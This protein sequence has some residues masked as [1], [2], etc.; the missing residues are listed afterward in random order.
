MRVSLILAMLLLVGCQQAPILPAVPETLKRGPIQD[1]RSGRSLTPRELAIALARSPRVM[2]GEQHDNPDHHAVQLWL[3]QA[4]A[5]ERPQGSLLLEMFTP[6]QQ[7]RIDRVRE[8]YRA[9]GLPPDLTGALAWQSGWDWSLYGPII[10]FAL[11]QT[12]PVL[13]ANLDSGEIRDI[14]ARRPRLEGERSTSAAVKSRL[15]AEVRESHC[16]LLPERQMPAMLAVQQQRDRRMAQR[17]LD[18]PTPAVFFAGAFHARKDVGVPVHLQDLGVTD[19]TVVVLLAQE[20]TEV[21]VETADYV[22]YTP[23]MP[24]QDYCAQLRK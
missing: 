20:G 18:A 7:P 24:E 3:L 8:Q 21:D 10:R 2:V 4:M 14:Y 9:G 22:W 15:L 19:G 23:P 17:L 6:D 1:L 13:A 12:Y 11:V 5:F 16:G